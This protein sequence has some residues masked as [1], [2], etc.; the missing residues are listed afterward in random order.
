MKHSELTGQDLHRA[1]SNTGF[2]SPVGIITP[3]VVGELYT[4][5]STNIVWIATGLANG[6]WTTTGI[7]TNLIFTA[8]LEKT[9]FTVAIHKADTTHD[10]YLSKE[11]WNT[12]SS[13]SPL[14]PGD[15]TSST[16]ITIT[17]GIG[18][19]ASSTGAIINIA[20]GY[21]LP[22]NGETI[23]W[24]A[25]QD[26]LPAADT[27]TDGYLT[28]GDWNRFN[29]GVTFTPG[30]MTTSTGIGIINGTG[31]TVTSTGTKIYIESGFYLP[32]TGD[33]STWDSKQNNLTIGNL[34]TSTGLTTTGGNGSI[35]GSGVS[36]NIAS[37]YHLPTNAEKSTW[38]TVTG[39]QNTLTIGTISSSTGLTTVGG[40]NAIIG[41]GVTVNVASGYHMP[42]TG[43]KSTW[44][45]VTGKENTLVK[46][47]L[48]TSTG[49]IVSNGTGAVIGTGTAVNIASGYV[50]PT[51]ANVS[52]WNGK[53]NALTTGNLTSSTGITIGSGTGSII[54][55]GT[56]VNVAS[57]YHMPTTGEVS[58][59]NAKQSALTNPVTGTGAANEITYFSSTSGVT[60]IPTFSYHSST[61]RVG[62]GIAD[63]QDMLHIY[64]TDNST[65]HDPDPQRNGLTVDGP[66][67]VDTAINFF[68]GG[69][70]KWAQ[71]I[72]RGEAGEFLYTY[73]YDNKNEPMVIS[74][75]G[76]VGINKASN[77]MNYHSIFSNY[78][79]LKTVTIANG[80]TGYTN[81]LVS[82]VVGS[83]S[84]DGRLT[85]AST[86]TGGIVTSVT[87][88][89]PG[90]L[91]QVANGLTTT[92]STGSGLIVNITSVY[93][94]DLSVS[95]VY[96]KTLLLWYKL[97]IATS[98]IPDTFNW[99]TS[100]YGVTYNT[101]YGGASGVSCLGTSQLL[102]NGVEILWEATTGH[103]VGHTFIFTAF[104]QLPQGSLTV[105]PS[106]F[107]EVIVTPNYDSLH[108][109]YYDYTASA[110]T[111][112]ETSG[113]N[114]I[115][116]GTKGCVYVGR[117]SKFNSVRFNIITA[118][119]NSG[120]AIGEYYNGVAW[121]VLPPSANV[122]DMTAVDGNSFQQ[123]GSMRG[124]KTALTNWSK[125]YPPDHIEDGYNLYW[126]RFRLTNAVTISPIARTIQPHRDI[127]FGVYS[128][129][130]DA[131]P[132]FFVDSQG[133]TN[134]G[135][136][137]Q[138]GKLKFL[139]GT[140]SNYVGLQVDGLATSTTYT[141][142]SDGTL[143]QGLVTNGAG[144][145]SW[146]TNSLDNLS[147]ASITT[148]SVDQVLKYNG[149]AWYNANASAVS[150]GKGV[151][152][153][154]DITAI[155]AAGSGPQTVPVYTLDKVPITATSETIKSVNVTPG[156][157]KLQ[158]GC[159]LYNTALT[160]TQIDGGV[161]SF[162]TWCYV[163]NN[164][165]TTQI[166]TSIHKVVVGTGTITMTLTGTT[167][168][169]TVTGAEPFLAADYNAGDASL[170]G[171]VQTPNGYFRINGYTNTHT[172][173][174]ET[175]STYTDETNVSSWSIHRY[176]FQATT[177]NIPTTTNA[178]ISV[179]STQPAFSITET[180]KLALH[181]FAT[182]TRNNTI[183]YF[184]YNGTAH[185][186][187]VTSPL[188]TRHNDLASLQGGNAT[189]RY[190]VTSTGATAV[191]N[192]S[193]TNTGDITL[194]SPNHGLSLSGQIIALGTPSG[195]TGVTTNAVTTTTH[196]HAISGFEPTLTKGNLT[197]STGLTIGSGT[198][199]II[200]TGTTVNIASGYHMPTTAE[201]TLWNKKSVIIQAVD[202]ATDLALSS[203]GIAC[204]TVPDIMNGLI[205]QS[206][207]ARV[208]TAGASGSANLFNF[209]IQTS[210]G[211]AYNMLSTALMIDAGELDSKDASVGYSIDASHKT[212]ATNDL[213]FVTVTQLNS[214]KPKG[215]IV[216]LLFA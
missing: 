62:V 7:D 107:T 182:S 157:A 215:L 41:T 100:I 172:V 131:L 27:S 164:T 175:L 1:K 74:T 106:M 156:N 139:S 124:E 93:T 44:D 47:N 158:L 88:T 207:A 35:I 165:G 102:N 151:S 43:E 82:T 81:G 130:L 37:G 133:Q 28:H 110:A 169:V 77:I 12:F 199:A 10:G 176:L 155:I 95:G 154:P 68:D 197:S 161:W 24:N 159:Y 152:F 163:S 160:G 11:D 184:T 112:N 30:D 57:G 26:L 51:T 105:S 140:T 122:V 48:T 114:F 205:L 118:A 23:I 200:G 204:F 121:V 87:I 40:S 209:K 42:T 39:K 46:G 149:S 174:I 85:V 91:Y 84:S 103:F 173:S 97:T 55:T 14:N 54:G 192:L 65:T 56:T 142:P 25:K 4:D 2:V 75:G 171:F 153:F 206:C 203:T 31:A 216:R 134:I 69:V 147:N 21:H 9:D 162:D 193:G 72:Y 126:M 50:L 198:G 38:D 109:T 148:P 19:T 104:P 187:S 202:M 128:G 16:G 8:P 49:L 52:T 117:E 22:T 138:A 59:W 98:G 213:V 36:V 111:T 113:F 99:A 210:T 45:T 73:N 67:D 86:S 96:D 137:G 101:T 76:R 115:P 5:F 13:G 170:C 195:I 190:H 129:H 196:T 120:A 167:R 136:Y 166:L 189:Q 212:L 61:G 127:R 94:N 15:L 90:S 179:T 108:P 34:T 119:S 17:G 208:V 123:A 53:Q 214:T 32:T 125:T 92:T 185:Y 177:G 29:S 143:N 144:A 6:D 168:T 188:I 18:A 183:A 33:K 191:G 194:A 83:N 63:P 58:T 180:D 66:T 60:G 70:G 78:G 71:Q 64:G 135:S 79:G 116:K 89:T 181:Y 3:T 80:G 178:L 211:T 20:S 141:L 146:R 186:S 201:Q 150:A 145:L 132:S